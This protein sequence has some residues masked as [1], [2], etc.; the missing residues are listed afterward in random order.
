M[1]GVVLMPPS[2]GR[3]YVER[4]RKIE[5]GYWVNR[6]PTRR[7]LTRHLSGL[8][9]DLTFLKPEGLDKIAAPE[10]MGSRHHWMRRLA[11]TAK[12]VGATHL[13]IRVVVA[14]YPGRSA[15]G[16]KRLGPTL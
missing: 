14:Q 16:R 10:T 9:I 4:I 7:W 13:L 3:F 15:V 11:R 8:G 1:M 2:L 5:R 6:I 12:Q